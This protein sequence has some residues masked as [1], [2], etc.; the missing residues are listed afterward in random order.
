VTDALQRV[1]QGFH[2]QLVGGQLKGLCPY[3]E[4]HAVIIS[5]GR[6]RVVA[7]CH[8]CQ[9]KKEINRLVAQYSKAE[10]PIHNP[11]P[12][13]INGP[14]RFKWGDWRLQRAE[15]ALTQSTEAQQ[16]LTGNGVDLEVAKRRRVGYQ[17]SWS[18][19]QGN[20]YPAR[21]VFPTFVDGE[22]VAVKLRAIGKFDES[23]KWRKF[24]RDQGVHHLYNRE[25]ITEAILDGQPVI[26]TESQRDALMLESNGY[27]AVSVDD[28]GHVL[29]PADLELLKQV[30]VI[31]AG[32][33]D[34]KGRECVQRL[35][36]KLNPKRYITVEA[37]QKLKDLGG[38]YLD[39]PEKF[40]QRLQKLIRR[41]ELKRRATLADLLTEDELVEEQGD[42][43]DYAIQKL[44]PLQR[45]TMV[46]GREKSLKS[47]LAYYFGK[48]AAN[49]AKVLDN[50]PS[51]KMPCIYIDAEA[52]ILGVYANWMRKIGAEKVRL[53]TLKYG[54]PA[55][56]DPSL[57]AICREFKPLLIIDSLSKFMRRSDGKNGNSWAAHEMEPVLEKV[58]QLCVAGAT[59]ILIHHA[60]KADA[61]VYRDSTAI[62]AGVDFIYS[63]A[64]E[65]DAEGTKRVH[66]T[67]LPSRGSQPPT[68]HLIGFPAL[69]DL[70]KFTLDGSQPTT[71]CEQ[72]VKYV[73]SHMFGVTKE[74][75]R[76]AIKGR[77]TNVDAAVK[78][79]QEAGLVEQLP[80]GKLVAV[81][82]RDGSVSSGV[83]TATGRED[84]DDGSGFVN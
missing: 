73:S 81:P 40:K 69:I 33:N 32:D 63:V 84:E 30:D 24:N 52:G 27:H 25:V 59:V 53:Y 38:L 15:Q 72:V 58:R 83:G 74:A 75:V 23:Q 36:A 80:D 68:L 1:V 6:K 10:T 64:M 9:R 44:V 31:L 22:L 50:Y 42:E 55:L 3:C 39:A 57:L 82:R 7:F 14:H 19:E 8:H 77:A 70:G 66:L 17:P 41:A 65:M 46:F 37:P 34:A 51:R 45:I 60:T 5:Q 26:V 78:E 16:Y 21:L 54:I 79:A 28:A 76:K 71:L 48:C 43:I 20:T 47:L 12:I 11:I 61:E 29:S 13:P 49:G 2:A 62:G 56:D 35:A 4:H 67:G 18:D